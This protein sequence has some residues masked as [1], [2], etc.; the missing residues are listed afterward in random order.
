VTISVVITE[1]L[2]RAID[3]D[4]TTPEEA[5]EKAQ[6]LYRGS[7]IVLDSSHFV[8]VAFSINNTKI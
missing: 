4:A 5:L 1:T 2:T 6:N 8:D 7:E 3:I